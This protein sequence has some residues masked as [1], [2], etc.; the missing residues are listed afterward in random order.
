MKSLPY[1]LSTHRPSQLGMIVLQSDETVEMDLRHL[2]PTEAELLVTRIPSSPT[3]SSDGL[4]QMERDVTGAASLLPRGA[5]LSVVGFGCTSGTA[6]IGAAR[7][8][9]LTRKGVETAAV[10]NPVSALIAAC[11]HLGV[12]RLALVS[13]YVEEVS[14]RLMEVLAE[15]GITIAAFA[16]FNEAR[17][18]RVVRIAPQAI[19]DAARAT[20]EDAPCD[21]VFLSCTNMRT[22]DVI[23]PI[24]AELGLPVLS[25]NLVLAWHMARLAGVSGPLGIDAA[26][27]RAR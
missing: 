22:L 20:A 16:S 4:G 24:E 10:T 2:L 27:T 17:E 14:H 21:A 13:P 26:L 1:T 9:D 25:S 12:T 19:V 6:Q 11:A 3:V 8:A 15:A 7:I 18:D 23:A 5:R